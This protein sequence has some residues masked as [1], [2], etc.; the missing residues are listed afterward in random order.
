MGRFAVWEALDAT[1][2]C[3]AK[4]VG[5]V[6]S[7]GTAVGGAYLKYRVINVWPLFRLSHY[8]WLGREV[9]K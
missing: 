3:W 4:L 6:N 2:S 7:L 1:Y 8:P 9:S 5:E